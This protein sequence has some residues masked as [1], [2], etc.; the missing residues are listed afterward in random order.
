MESKVYRLRFNP[1]TVEALRAKARE[2]A[3]A[4]QRDVTWGD[5]VREGVEIVLAGTA[6]KQEVSA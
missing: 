3:C 1:N 6:K 4:Q 2:A 5:L